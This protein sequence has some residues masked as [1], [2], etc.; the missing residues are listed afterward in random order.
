MQSGDGA[1]TVPSFFIA[2]SL[3]RKALFNFFRGQGR[4]VLRA[5]RSRPFFFSHF[6]LHFTRAFQR[7]RFPAVLAVKGRDERERTAPLTA[8][9]R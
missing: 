9:R 7:R 3:S 2:Y 6:L 8:P 4:L 1:K 5:S